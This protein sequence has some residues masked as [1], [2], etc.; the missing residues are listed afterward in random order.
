MDTTFLPAAEVSSFRRIAA[1]MWDRPRDPTIYGFVDIDVGDTLERLERFRRERGIKLTMTHLVAR[2]VGKALAA[3]PELNAK[4]GLGRRILLR[5]Q[6]DVLLSVA[7]AGGRDLSGVRI[8]NADRLSLAQIAALANDRIEKTRHGADPSYQRS[9]SLFGR[10]PSPLSRPLVRLTD[11]LSNEL[12]LHLP[13][14]GMPRDP[15]GS[16]IVTNVGMLGIDTAFAPLVPLSRCSMLF[17][18]TEVRQRP[19]VVGD[20]VV[21][22]PVLRLCASFDHRIVDGVQ[23]GRMSEAVVRWIERPFDE[24]DSGSTGGESWRAA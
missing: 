2:A 13:R 3:N 15:F 10:L 4:V 22:R 9:R 18:V 8:E 24:A 17:L 19:R 1:A 14:L 16:A 23:A 12:H 20:Q 6:V 11:L 21:P 7:V 5:Q